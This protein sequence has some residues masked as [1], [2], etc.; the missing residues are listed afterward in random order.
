LLSTFPN[1]EQINLEN[2]PIKTKNLNNLTAEQFTRLVDGIKNKKFR[3]ASWQGTILMDLLEH[4]QQ[5]VSHGQTNPQVQAHT[6][7]LQ[8]LIQEQPSEIKPVINTKA[9]NNSQ[10]NRKSSNFNAFYLIGGLMLFGIA[11]LAVGY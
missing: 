7:Y 8:E 6:A 3:V 11:I 9:A 4:A 10:N 5:L 2:N 1:L